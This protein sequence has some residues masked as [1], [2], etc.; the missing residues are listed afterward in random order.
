[1][2]LHGAI[3]SK[4]NLPNYVTSD[5]LSKWPVHHFIDSYLYMQVMNSSHLLSFI[6]MNTQLVSLLRGFKVGKATLIH[7]GAILLIFSFAVF[8]FTMI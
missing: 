1:M 4:T 2:H 6:V 3:S 8:A 5:D 7:C